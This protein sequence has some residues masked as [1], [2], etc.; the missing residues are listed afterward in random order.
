MA[1][2]EK[3]RIGDCTPNPA[4]RRWRA[5]RLVEAG[6]DRTLAE[7]VAA[8]ARFDLHALIG[9]TERDCPPELACRILAPL[10]STW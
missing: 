6:F 4:I 3:R 2:F 5:N 9:L 8:D 1:T 7:R 10:D